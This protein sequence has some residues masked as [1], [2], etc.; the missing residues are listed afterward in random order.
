[1]C[2]LNEKFL[3][4]FCFYFLQ[5]SNDPF[6]HLK[7]KS[8]LQC[9][10][11]AMPFYI[12][13]QTSQ[14]R[15]WDIPSRTCV[16]AKDEVTVMQNYWGSKYRKVCDWHRWKRQ[17]NIWISQQDTDQIVKDT[18]RF[19][20]HF[21]AR[22]ALTGFSAA[23]QRPPAS[24]VL[25]NG[26]WGLVRYAQYGQVMGALIKWWKSFPLFPLDS[27]LSESLCSSLDLWP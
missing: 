27:L 15:K 11:Y 14:K 26:S 23:N 3:G 22:E 16:S 24:H 4:A 18:G 9:T 1:M 21:T 7:K 10:E 13:E 2:L 12:A 19:L 17:S 20:S 6:I 25:L 8:F 5:R